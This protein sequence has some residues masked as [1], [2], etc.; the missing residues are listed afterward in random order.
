MVRSSKLV[1][2]VLVAK[3]V[4]KVELKYL[5]HE[6]KVYDHLRLIQGGCIPV[7]LGMVNL[8]LPCY[9]NAGIYFIAVLLARLIDYLTSALPPRMKLVFS[10]K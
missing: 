4:E 8:N 9:Y 7:S 2:R 1:T 5:V 10:I 3:G 6:S